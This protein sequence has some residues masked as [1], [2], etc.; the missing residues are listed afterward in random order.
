MVAIL[1]IFIKFR[2]EKTMKRIKKILLSLRV[3]F[4]TLTCFYFFWI[5]RSI[6]V[7]N[8]AGDYSGQLR[9]N[10]I[11]I[12][13]DKD[14]TYEYSYT[15]RDSK[16]YDSSGEWKLYYDNNIPRISLE[17]INWVDSEGFVKNNC[18]FVNTF[19]KRDWYGKIQIVVN[20]DAGWYLK[21]INNTTR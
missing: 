5:S 6:N 12:R 19:I 8:L 17:N 2:I 14:G 7:S 10:T 9:D 21:K 18:G 20:H 16:K 1:E 3:Y 13:I 15:S 4:I 11:F